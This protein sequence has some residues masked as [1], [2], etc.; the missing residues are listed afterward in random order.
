MGSSNGRYDSNNYGNPNGKNNDTLKLN[1]KVMMWH[2]Q[3]WYDFT[4]N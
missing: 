1:E 3:N 4:K 2:S